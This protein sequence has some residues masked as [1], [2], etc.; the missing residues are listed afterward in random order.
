MAAVP[1]VFARLYLQ[2]RLVG[3][4][5]PP[6]V[7]AVA[8]SAQRRNLGGGPIA[9]YGRHAWPDQ[10]IE[11][12]CGTLNWTAWLASYAYGSLLQAGPQPE[13]FRLEGKEA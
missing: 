8:K 6:S 10:N 3:P 9:Q 13:E 7:Y 2:Y 12:H 5:H 11:I 4:G 1:F